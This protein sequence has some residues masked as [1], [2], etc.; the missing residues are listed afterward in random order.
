MSVYRTTSHEGKLK[1]CPN[2]CQQPKSLQQLTIPIMEPNVAYNVVPT[3]K[4][5]TQHGTQGSPH[6]MEENIAYNIID[7]EKYETL[8]DQ[9]IAYNIVE[10]S[11]ETQ[12][13]CKKNP[14]YNIVENANKIRKDSQTQETDEYVYIVPNTTT[15][16]DE[17][18][19]NT[20]Q[21]TTQLKHHRVVSILAIVFALL[22]LTLA[23]AAL[24]HTSIELRNVNQEITSITIIL[25]NISDQQNSQILFRDV[26]NINSILEELEPFYL[27]TINNPASSCSDIPQDRS[28]GEYWIRNTTSSLVQVYCDMNGTS[29]SCNTAGGWMRVANLDMTDPN[30]NC[31]D[32]F[33]LT[34]RTEPPL[35]T[36]G[37]TGELRTGCTSFPIQTYGVEY[38]HVCGRIISY[39]NG[40]P[41][42][43]AP[44]HRRRTSLTI[45]RDYV[46]GISLTH[47][48]SPRQH[49]WTFACAID[50]FVSN[51]NTQSSRC[52]CTRPND[53]FL[54]TVPPFIGQ[55]YFCETGAGAGDRGRFFA[56]DPLWDGQ[57]CADNST[58]CEFNNP[59]WFCKQLPQPTTDD[60]EMRICFDQGFPDEDTPIEIM[61]MYVR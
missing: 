22:S 46:D 20:S 24:V 58:C 8:K 27:G 1:K 52:P 40:R 2:C 10:T 31:P 33:N 61:E 55:D 3:T 59:P 50:E 53:A 44:F 47:G 38:S 13:S 41:D 36:C 39:Q 45:D 32:G 48:Q 57:G 43:F 11:T 19:T 49:I 42:A 23:V 35:R 26:Q 56:N 14:T 18:T 28:S 29:C 30:Q 25:N 9:N 6:Q 60:I 5:V 51:I 37:R 7:N 21:M 15:R 12:R 4:N 34:I 54:G 17:H 16:K